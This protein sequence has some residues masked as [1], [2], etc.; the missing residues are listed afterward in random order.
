M[1]ERLLL[2]DEYFPRLEALGFRYLHTVELDGGLPNALFV[3]DN[4]HHFLCP[5]AR[6]FPDEIPMVPHRK[7]DALLDKARTVAGR[8][9]VN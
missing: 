8:S 7:L 9:P 5:G 3:H 6:G 4:G 1:A 2:A